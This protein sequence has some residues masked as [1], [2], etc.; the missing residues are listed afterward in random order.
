MKR[1]VVCIRLS[2]RTL[3]PRIQR[4]HRKLNPTPT[5]PVQRHVFDIPI[6]HS[7]ISPGLRYLQ[8]DNISD[9][10]AVTLYMHDFQTRLSKLTKE[11]YWNLA[12][13]ANSSPNQF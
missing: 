6:K 8:H 11:C 3:S 12:N 9:G 10:S 7:K 5:I 2:K 1:K 13:H 4:A